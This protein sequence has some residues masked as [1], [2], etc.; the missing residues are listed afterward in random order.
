VWSLPD[1]AARHGAA[2]RALIGRVLGEPG[3]SESSRLTA[4]R[5]TTAQS[6]V[7]SST[8][9]YFASGRRSALWSARGVGVL[10]SGHGRA[11][12]RGLAGL[13]DGQC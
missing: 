9:L 1:D 7:R 8:A 3:E 5:E 4:E 13:A 12:R 10:V 2:R 6:A 11:G